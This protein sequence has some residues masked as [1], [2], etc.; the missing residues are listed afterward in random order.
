VKK[1]I[2][3]GIMLAGIVLFGLSGVVADTD[4]P[5]SEVT[6][7]ASNYSASE[8]IY[9]LRIEN[10]NKSGADF[11]WSTS[12]ET[13]GSIEYVY[14]KLAQLYNPQ[15]PGGQ[16]DV[17]VTV[18]PARIKAELYYVKEHH[19]RVDNLDMSYDPF[20]QY[21]IKSETYSG[22]AY[23]LSGELVLVDTG[24]IR[25]WQTWWY[26]LILL[27]IGTFLGQIIGPKGSNI[28]KVGSRIRK[29][30]QSRKAKRGV[31]PLD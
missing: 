1:L 8:N 13:K 29:D 24:L 31:V 18:V 6:T 5:N 16:Q 9:A 22:E 17:L 23:T 27:A 28:R 25:W 12:I 7:S 21:T 19:I 2:L 30:F 14:A 26:P 10:I 4:T 3:L 11:Y 20:V 15:S